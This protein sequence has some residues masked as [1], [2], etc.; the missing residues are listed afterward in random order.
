MK[1][2]HLF[3]LILIVFGSE[4]LFAQRDLSRGGGQVSDKIIFDKAQALVEIADSLFEYTN[5]E[6]LSIPYY[7]EA[8]AL[9]KTI[10]DFENIYLMNYNLAE[11]ITI[12]LNTKKQ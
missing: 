7:K 9:F 5:E 4:F 12:Y 3:C 10:N 8:L 6:A 11:S 2:R 1:N